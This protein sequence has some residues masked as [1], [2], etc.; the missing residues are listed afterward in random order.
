ME[1]TLNGKKNKR[2]AEL[3]LGDSYKP[4]GVVQYEQPYVV[5]VEIEGTTPILFH[6][7]DC[8]EVEAKSKAKKGSRE[9]KTDNLESYVYRVPK[10]NDLGIP[11]INFKQCL[12]HSA[13]FN[14]D[15]RSPRKSA[16]DIF[17][18]GIQVNPEV[19]S[20]GIKHW[21]FEDKRGVIIQKAG[22]IARVRPAMKAGWKTTFFVRVLLSDYI[23]PELLNE[24]AVRAGS[25]IGLLDFR[26]EFGQFFLKKFEVVNA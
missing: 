10:S 9:K 21:D 8:D 14:Q 7:Y 26:P 6:R 17:K 19:A 13:K 16:M 11:G 12:V 4:K 15:P 24:V 2:V 18:A 23:S 22:R 20:L 25:T 1:A 3:N 5:Q